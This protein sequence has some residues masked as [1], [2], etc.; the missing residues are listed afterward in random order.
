ME[1]KIFFENGNIKITNARFIAG[2]QTY[3]MA[4]INSVKVT[5]TNITESKTIPGILIAIGII[6]LLIIFGK[7]NSFSSYVWPSLLLAVGVFWFFSIKENFLYRVVLTTSSGEASAFESTN[8]NDILTIEKALN[9]VI[10][11]RG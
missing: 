2:S 6:W 9:D 1:E 7:A 11:F 8:K 4:A 3:A 5:K 10:I